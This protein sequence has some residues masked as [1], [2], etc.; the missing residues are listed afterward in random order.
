MYAVPLAPDQVAINS[1][2]PGEDISSKVDPAASPPPPPSDLSSD[3]SQPSIPIDNTTNPEVKQNLSSD[4]AV[5][6]Q[7][8]KNNEVLNSSNQ[9]EKMDTEVIKQTQ[10]QEGG[11]GHAHSAEEKSEDNSYC[12]KQDVIDNNSDIPSDHDTDV[13]DTTTP[14]YDFNE[15]MDDINSKM[16]RIGMT[17]AIGKK[18]LAM[19]Y[20]C[21]SRY[22]LSDED[23]IDFWKYMLNQDDL[24]NIRSCISKKG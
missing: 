17:P 23:L 4:S 20:G 12:E 13:S 19:V 22:K 9:E 10:P 14:S 24:R 15:I 8:E 5:S 16:K 18:Y 21:C 11:G 6:K 1:Q 3:T 2:Q 7:T